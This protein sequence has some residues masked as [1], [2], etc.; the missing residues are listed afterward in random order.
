MAGCR[1]HQ[2]AYVAG[3]GREVEEE[4]KEKGVKSGKSDE[5]NEGA[6]RKWGNG[7]GMNKEDEEEGSR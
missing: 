5:G 4:L 6:D 7:T 1:G 3:R 2:K